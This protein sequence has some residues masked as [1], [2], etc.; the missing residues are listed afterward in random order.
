MIH[1][2]LSSAVSSSLSLSIGSMLLYLW[3]LI[4]AIADFL[5]LN[6]L[7]SLTLAGFIALN[8]Q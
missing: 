3:G 6:L 5:D 1:S 2:K 8:K 4:P 7:I